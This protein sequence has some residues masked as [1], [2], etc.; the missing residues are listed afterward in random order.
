MQIIRY[1]NLVYLQIAN[2]MYNSQKKFSVGLKKY[3]NFNKDDLLI[4]KNINDRFIC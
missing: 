3:K 1:F 4:M 2:K